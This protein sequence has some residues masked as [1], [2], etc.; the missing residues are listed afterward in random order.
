MGAVTPD[1]QLISGGLTVD[2]TVI[3]DGTHK[4]MDGMTVKSVARGN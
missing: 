2:D 3:S 1:Y 4:T